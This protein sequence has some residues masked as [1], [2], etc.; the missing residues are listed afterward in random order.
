MAFKIPVFTLNRVP[1]FSLFRQPVFLLSVLLCFIA[2]CSLEK[3]SALNRN[4]QNLTAHYNV[5]FNAKELL[6]LKQEGYATTF[7]DNYNELLNVYPDTIAQSTTPDKDLDAA[8]LK[9]NTIITVKE[10]SHYLGDA[11]LVL[12][13]ANYLGGNYFNAVEYFSYVIRSFPLQPDLVQ[14]SLAW[15]ARSL[16]YLGQLPQAKLVLDTALQNINP[17]KRIT[18]DV[19]AAKLQYDINAQDYKDGEEMAVEALK[20]CN[21]RNYRLRWTFI[22]AQLQELNHKPA[23]S[24]CELY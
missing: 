7:V 14:E 4:L 5:L 22:L 10:Q 16:M 19:Y 17:K 8:M 12:G 13:K 23:E 11:Y 9:A 6:R 21:D 1:L 2:G 24:S 15:K 20:Y 3:K 18:A